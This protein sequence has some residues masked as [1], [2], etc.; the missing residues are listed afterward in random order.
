M[1]RTFIPGLIDEVIDTVA[2]NFEKNNNSKIISAQFD[3]PV[4]KLELN[5]LYYCFSRY[6]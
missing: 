6:K 1:E 5:I 4:T 3:L 2:S